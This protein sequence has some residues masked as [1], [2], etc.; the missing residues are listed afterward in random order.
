MTTISPKN[1]FKK[2]ALLA[3]NKP[4]NQNTCHFMRAF[5]NVK[6]HKLLQLKGLNSIKLQPSMYDRRRHEELL[7]VTLTLYKLKA[8]IEKISKAHKG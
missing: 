3:K 1:Q 6:K 5:N 8:Y 4:L 7:R 2:L